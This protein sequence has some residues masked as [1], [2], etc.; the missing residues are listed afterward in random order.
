[1]ESEVRK[2]IPDLPSSTEITRLAR[3]P[4]AFLNHLSNMS[5][6]NPSASDIETS[7]EIPA[8]RAGSTTIDVPS[9]AEGLTRDLDHPKRAASKYPSPAGGSPS[10]DPGLN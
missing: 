1:M 8:P 6:D 7:L 4:S 5:T 10:G 3:S 2:S 9:P